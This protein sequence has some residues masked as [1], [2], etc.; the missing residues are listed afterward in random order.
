M[1]AKLALKVSVS[2][3]CSDCSKHATGE[4][5]AGLIPCYLMGS[6]STFCRRVLLSLRIVIRPSFSLSSFF[7]TALKTDTAK[8]EKALGLGGSRKLK[9]YGGSFCEVTAGSMSPR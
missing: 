2:N 3:L 9:R 8:S 5:S 4:V 1:I 7:L 6:C